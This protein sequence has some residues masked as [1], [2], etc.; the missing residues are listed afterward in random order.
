VCLVARPLNESEAGGPLALTETSAFLCHNDTV[1]MLFSRNLLKKSSEVS[2]KTRSPQ[3]SPS[4]KSQAT[5]HTT[6]KK[7]RAFPLNPGR[8]V[9]LHLARLG[10]QSEHRIRC[11]MPAHRACH[12]INRQEFTSVK[13]QIESEFSP[14]KNRRKFTN[15]F[16]QYC[17]PFFFFSQ[18]FLTANNPCLSTTASCPLHY[19]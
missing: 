19:S 12:I 4:L 8:A 15:S 17:T 11:I 7:R 5:K 1:L 2:V 3:A 14:W 16:K 18:P 6:E 9:S 10:S 13:P